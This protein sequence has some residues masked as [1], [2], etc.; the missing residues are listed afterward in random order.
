MAEKKP[1]NIYEFRLVNG[2]GDHKAHQFGKAF[3]E[4]I[5]DWKG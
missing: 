3:L 4:A 5:K 2:V 1:T